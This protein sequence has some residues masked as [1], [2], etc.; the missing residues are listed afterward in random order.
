MQIPI[1]PDD[2]KLLI[3]AGTLLIAIGVAGVLFS[4]TSN[5]PSSSGF[6]SSYSTASEGAKAAYVLLGEM[7]YHVERGLRG[8]D[9]LPKGVAGTVLVLAE[10]SIPPSAEERA[11]V[12][13][14]VREGGRVLA[15]GRT[16]ASLLSAGRVVPTHEPLLEPQRFAAEVPGPLTWH[17]PEIEM[18]SNIRWEPPLSDQQRFYGDK[19]GPAVVGFRLGKGEVIWWADSM[20]LTNYGLKRASNLMLFVN[21]VGITRGPRQSKLILWDEYFHG[22]RVGLWSYLRRTPAPWAL[23]QFGLMAT[24][25]LLTFSRRSGP[26]RA[27]RQPSRLSPLEFIDTLG[28]LYQRKGAAP[29]ALAT[30]YHR[31]RFLLLRRLAL[32]PTASP[33]E[34]SRGVR[35]RLGWAI[36]GFW[37][38]LQRCERGVKSRELEDAQALHLI[39]ELHDY[40]RRFRLEDYFGS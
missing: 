9:T 24:A 32:P 8:P 21:S 23:I 26:V 39:Q 22:E 5:A 10:P 6:P 29:E 12:R 40:A 15:T 38:T 30:A 1:A 27:L 3:V 4:P 25:A 35:E 34:I 7:G 37:E 36:P 17:A 14:F 11:L 20:P 16:G 28:A 18:E 19:D 2:R 31:F 13:A 33:D